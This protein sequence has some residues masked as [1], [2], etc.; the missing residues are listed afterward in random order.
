MPGGLEPHWA[1]TVVP[2]VSMGSPAASHAVR[3]MS[4]VCSPVWVT[5]PP[6]A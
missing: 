1:S 4:K 6:T 5:Q 2:A 3:V